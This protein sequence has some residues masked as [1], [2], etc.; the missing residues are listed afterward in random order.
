MT[1]PFTG[2]E[3]QVGTDIC[4][5]VMAGLM[6]LKPATTRKYLIERNCGDYWAALAQQLMTKSLDCIGENAAD[7]LKVT[8]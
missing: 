7:L 3:K 5:A 1:A 4:A 2:I 6:G 8:R